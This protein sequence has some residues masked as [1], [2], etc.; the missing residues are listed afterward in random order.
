MVGLQ[1][2]GGN[3]EP[4]RTSRG[5]LGQQRGPDTLVQDQAA[6]RITGYFS[7]A[8]GRN[9]TMAATTVIHRKL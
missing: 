2:V 3:S 6:E 9:L 5:R 4:R 8:P 7:H 1:G